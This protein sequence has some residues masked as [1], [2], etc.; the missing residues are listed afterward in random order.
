M[1]KTWKP[2]VAGFLDLLGGI[3]QI[4]VYGFLLVYC[5]TN[6]LWIHFHVGYFGPDGGLL[7]IPLIFGVPLVIGGVYA[8]IGGISNLKRKKYRTALVGSVMAFIPFLVVFLLMWGIFGN[9]L[10]GIFLTTVFL[11][12][13]LGITA[14]LL[15]RQSKNEFERY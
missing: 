10:S 8:I 7:F 3:I 5:L 14:I 9:G 12:T 15:T 1:N 4:S 11:T 13:L 6:I 2:E